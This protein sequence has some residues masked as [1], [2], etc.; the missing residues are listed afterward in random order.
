MLIQIYLCSLFRTVAPFTGERHAQTSG[1]LQ[2]NDAVFLL[3]LSLLSCSSL[4][5]ATIHTL[6]QMTTSQRMSWSLSRTSNLID[7]CHV[8]PD[9]HTR[10]FQDLWG[11]LRSE[12]PAKMGSHIRKLANN[13]DFWLRRVERAHERDS[14]RCMTEGPM[15]RQC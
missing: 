4:V 1:T 7:W 12:K 6:G 14:I 9:E 15:L 2:Q 10:H 13:M 11:V 3:P 5:K 8:Y